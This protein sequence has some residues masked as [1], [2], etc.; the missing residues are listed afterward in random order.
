MARFSLFEEIVPEVQQLIADVSAK[1]KYT[2]SDI[3]NRTRKAILSFNDAKGIASSRLLKFAFRTVNPDD[4]TVVDQNI[5]EN[6]DNMTMNNQLELEDDTSEGSIES[7]AKVVHNKQIALLVVYW[8]EDGTTGPPVIDVSFDKDVEKGETFRGTFLADDDRIGT[9]E[10]GVMIDTSM[11]VSKTFS[12]K[13]YLPANSDYVIKD[14]MVKIFLVDSAFMIQNQFDLARVTASN[15]L[16]VEATRAAKDG[17]AESYVEMLK[18]QAIELITDI[19][20]MIG[21]NAVPSSF[22][23]GIDH[24]YDRKGYADKAFN[25]AQPDERFVEVVRDEVSGKRVLR[26]I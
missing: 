13:W 21:G 2:R 12:I 11:I 14:C 20:G 26:F 18:A 5:Y 4:L 25:K 1:S 6:V 16:K 8:T 22:A 10:N 17:E 23:G 3:I 24:E 7:I 15:I 19:Q 9:I